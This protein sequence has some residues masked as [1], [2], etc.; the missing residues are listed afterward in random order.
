MA[1][2]QQT[3]LGSASDPR[4]KTTFPVGLLPIVQS[5]PFVFTSLGLALLFIQIGRSAKF[6]L[7]DQRVKYCPT[8]DHSVF[9]TAI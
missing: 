2:P 3:H 9:I 1:V 6:F 5:L 7:K 8:M 4:L